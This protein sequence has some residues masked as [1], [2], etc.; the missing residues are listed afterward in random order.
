[1]VARRIDRRVQMRFDA[2]DILQETF[3][4]AFRGLNEYLEEPKMPFDFWLRS[5]T[6]HKLMALLRREAGTEKRDPRREIPLPPE[7]TSGVIHHLAKSIAG[8]HTDAVRAELK[9]RVHEAIGHLDL[10]DQEIIWLRNFEQSSNADTA[11]LLEIDQSTASHRYRRAL[12]K[13]KNILAHL[14]IESGD[15]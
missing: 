10:I 9:E 11:A 4:D 6:W 12:K 1:M 13:L 2:S 7:T 14:S 5:I 15:I 8:P 3:T